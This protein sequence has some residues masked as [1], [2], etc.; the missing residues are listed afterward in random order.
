MVREVIL[1]EAV[2]F[3]NIDVGINL[4]L[5]ELLVVSGVLIRNRD[6]DIA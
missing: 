1:H 3:G 6:D 5:G 2:E 4:G